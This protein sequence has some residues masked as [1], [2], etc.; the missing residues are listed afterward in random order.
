MPRS[1]QPDMLRTQTG[2]DARFSQPSPE[3]ACGAHPLS[4]W[5]RRYGVAL[6]ALGVVGLVRYLLAPSLDDRAV[7][8]IFL[9]AVMLSA[10]YG[11]SRPGLLA[12]GLSVPIILYGFLPPRYTP[13]L[14]L[15]GDSFV[16]VLFLAAGVA[17]SLLIGHLHLARQRA[18]AWAYDK[19]Q[20]E[21]ALKVAKAEAERR[22]QSA[23]AAERLLH[24]L[25]AHVPE[26]ITIATGPP[27]SPSWPTADLPWSC[28]IGRRRTWLTSLLASIFRPMGFSWLTA[29]PDPPRSRYRSTGPAIW[30][31]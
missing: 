17:I 4:S 29:A 2:S 14:A 7:F 27:D 8:M 6:A 5:W 11:G 21:E 18:E 23:E 15:V 10:W 12:T 13:A 30:V 25:L 16:L 20:A 24:T 26:G 28:W 31:K 1:P 19:A 3:A 22:T 9:C